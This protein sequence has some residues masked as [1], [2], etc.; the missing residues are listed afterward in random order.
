MQKIWLESYHH[1]GRW[2]LLSQLWVLL[3]GFLRNS[4]L[5]LP[6]W[7][8]LKSCYPQYLKFSHL[9]LSA[10][11]NKQL[12]LNVF[13]N[14]LNS[15]LNTIMTCLIYTLLFQ[16]TECATVSCMSLTMNCG[17]FPNHHQLAGLFCSNRVC[18]KRLKLNF[19]TLFQSTSL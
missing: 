18:F 3:T 6:G 9:L 14:P 13:L 17:Y 4:K 2:I 8:I 19:L 12:L 10:P 7:R 15:V 5:L 11:Q 1:K 16:C